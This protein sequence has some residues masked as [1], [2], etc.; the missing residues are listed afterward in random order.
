MA[1]ELEILSVFKEQMVQ[2]LDE[3]IESFPDQADFVIF[4]I[5]IKDQIPIASVMNYIVNK[6]LPLRELVKNRDETFFLDN[7]ILFDSMDSKKS[8][9][10]NQFQNLWKSSQ[11]SKDD[12]DVLWLWFDTFLALA[13]KYV[14]SKKSM[15]VSENKESV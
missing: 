11:V 13:N 4:R 12:K 9:K 3:L 10:I 7:N 1:A 2:F 14:D 5:F 8:N 15:N 6:L